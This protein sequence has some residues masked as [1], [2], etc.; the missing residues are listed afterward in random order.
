LF[1]SV[2]EVIFLKKFAHKNFKIIFFYFYK[3]IFDITHSK[4]SKNIL[5]KR[6]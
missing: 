3:T 6:I 4:Q 1:E 2:V 5:K